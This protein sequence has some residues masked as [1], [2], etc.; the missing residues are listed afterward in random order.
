MCRNSTY[1]LTCN[2]AVSVFYTP[3][4]LNLGDGFP[5]SVKEKDRKDQVAKGHCIISGLFLHCFSN[6]TNITPESIASRSWKLCNV[7]WL[8][9]LKNHCSA[10][11][12]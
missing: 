1:V 12:D 10:Y 6:L 5:S 8:N 2:C 3:L 7:L 11:F 9:F 4:L